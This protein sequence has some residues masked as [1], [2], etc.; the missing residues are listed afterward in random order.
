[1]RSTILHFF[2]IFFIFQN[3][4]GQYTDVVNSNRPGESMSAYSVGKKIIQVESGLNYVS[5][6]HELLDYEAK[7]MNLDLVA[8][9]GFFVEELEFIGGL[10]LQSDTYKDTFNPYNLIEEQRT[11][12]K[13]ISIGLKFLVYDPFKNY[14]EKI[15]IYSWKANH[16]FKWRQ[17]IPAVSLYAGTNLNLKSNKFIDESEKIS[18]VSPKVMLITQNIFNKGYVFVTNVFYDKI[19]NDHKTVGYVVTLTKG[20][21]DKWTGFIENKGVSG[22]YYV[23]AIVTAGAA[24]LINK[25]IQLDASISKNFKNTPDIIYGGIGVSWRSDKN[26]KE[27]KIA[28]SKDGKKRKKENSKDEKKSKSKKRIDEVDLEKTK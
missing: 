22:D 18:I 25:N 11:G 5:S 9:Y 24:Y 19:T 3:N 23:D 27:V 1:M 14:K 16:K 28:T 6:K 20:F 15:N 2:F 26:Y 10:N 13:S 8:R 4:Y 17:F 21:N 12:I 7:G